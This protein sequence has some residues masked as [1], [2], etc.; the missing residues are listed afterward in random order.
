MEKSSKVVWHHSVQVFSNKAPSYY[1]RLRNAH[2]CICK[3]T[4]SFAWCP[5]D[6]Q[7]VISKSMWSIKTK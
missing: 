1:R 3:K 2:P 7:G 5:E 4:S 6:T